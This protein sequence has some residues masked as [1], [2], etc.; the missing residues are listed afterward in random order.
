MT[1]ASEMWLLRTLATI[2]REDVSAKVRLSDSE[3]GTSRTVR[4]CS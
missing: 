2:L 3:F 1:K 4:L